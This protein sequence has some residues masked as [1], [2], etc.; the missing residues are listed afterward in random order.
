[1]PELLVEL[2]SE[3]IPARMQARA[4]EDLKRLVCEGLSAQGL[5]FDSAAA[6]ATPRRLTLV[7]EGLPLRQPDVREEKKGPKEGAPD[8]AIQGFMK[9]NGLADIGEAE[10]RDTPKGRFY[11]VVR[12]IPGRESREVLAEALLDATG[13]LT[14]P[15]S[16]RWAD[17]SFRW[18]RPL[19]SILAVFDGV[20]LDGELKLGTDGGVPLGN[21]TRGHRFLAPDAFI[22][23]DFAD[24][25]EKLHRAFVVL[26]AEVRKATILER[27]RALVAKAGVT[28]KEDENLLD[29]VAGLVEWPVVHIGNI[30]PG[31]MDL[32]DEVLVSS[33]KAHQKYFSTLDAEGRIAPRFVFVANIEATD[34]GAAIVDGN[35]RVL[36]AR[37][38][39]AR[40]FWDQDRKESLEQRLGALNGIVFHAKLGTLADKVWRMEALASVLAPYIPDCDKDL[41]WRAAR[42]AKADLVTDMV[43][44][45]PDLQGVMGAHY[46][47]H[48]GE[49]EAVAQAILEHYAPQ[50]P[51]DRCPSAPVSVA[52]ALADKLDTLAGF[53]AIGETPTGSKDPFALRRAALGVIRLIVEN[54][55]RLPL[56]DILEQALDAQAAAG[57]APPSQ[58]VVADLMTFFA[59][60]LKVALRDRGVRHDLVSAVFALGSEDDLVRLLGRVEALSDF[61]ASE[62]G[63]N[64]LVAH[65]RATNIVRIE[66]KKDDRVYDGDVDRLLLK[67]SEE[68]ALHDALQAARGKAETA[69]KAEKFGDAM[70]AMAELRRPVDAF[71][72]NVMVNAEDGALR[73]NRL[74][75]LS[76]IDEVLSRVA[77]FS[78]IER[79]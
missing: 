14:W 24:Y 10:L 11:F 42:L 30:D 21:E 79:Q 74:K 36:A 33:L 4:A 38:A 18:V 73:A 47:R 5:D 9:A 49:D 68:L 29:E 57:A 13:K 8:Q 20:A 55:L 28:L 6:Y 2:F 65:E 76:S 78:R 23:S 19:H 15:K 26:E 61:L 34:G 25:R 52:V 62:D 60:R 46:A 51:S 39:D 58:E 53:W 75:L 27:A 17:G 71:F 59:D 69:L 70:T 50:G 67:E 66:Q 63:A 12:D 3:E 1:M 41:A 7:I 40:F 35:E 72:D 37:L 54:K 43:G 77:N 56:A 45:F 31:F 44:E 48:D 64:L 32:P 16:M 22:V